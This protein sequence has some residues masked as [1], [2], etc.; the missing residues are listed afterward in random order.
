MT[1]RTRHTDRE[2]E[3]ELALLREKLLRMAGRVEQMIGESVRAV[4]DRDGDLARGVIDLDKKVNVDEVETDELCLTILAKRQ[5]L[6]SD[7]RFITLALKMV[8]DL[9]RIGD[10]AVNISE[11]ALEL[12]KEPALAH[13]DA[14]PKMATM[15]QAMVRQAIDAFV[16]GDAEK[17]QRVI[18][19]DAEV[20]DL[21]H[22]TFGEVLR[23]MR[24]EGL[25]IHRGI[26]LQSVAKFIERIGDHGT[27]LAEE[28]VF[29]IQGKDIRHTRS[30]GLRSDEG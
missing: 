29:L 22:Q 27:N 24:T 8:T 11:R 6:A 12:A 2:Y 23:R 18:A 13:V 14:I 21:Y 9:E 28:V 20:D 5:P 25:D 10:L 16:E 30:R 3:R 17:A 26:H 19:Q 7:L 15:V 4:V 1:T